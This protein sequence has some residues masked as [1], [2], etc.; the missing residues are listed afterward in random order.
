MQKFKIITAFFMLAVFAIIFGACS[1]KD[2]RTVVYENE[3]KDGNSSCFVEYGKI[4]D[5]SDSVILLKSEDKDAS[6]ITYFGKNEKKNS[7]WV[8]RGLAAEITFQ[9][10]PSEIDVN[11]CF[12]WTV[13][14][15]NNENN[16]LASV[17]VCFRK[18]QN[19]VRVGFSNKSSEESNQN[20]TN[21]DNENAK[22][23]SDANFYV[24]EVSFYSNIE[25]EILY[26]IKLK[27][28]ENKMY[29]SVIGEGLKNADGE[30]IKASDI[31]GV[32]SAMLSYMTVPSLKIKKVRLLEN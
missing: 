32:R 29:F 23:L 30:K 21:F 8:D 5:K 17:N 7:V 24:L 12:N 3:F 13:V 11:K 2:N 20:A 15:N 16:P 14:L 18:Y 1:Q 27:D 25:N 31:G 22:S 9:I 28:K 4:V 19:L 6:A 10:I 26:S